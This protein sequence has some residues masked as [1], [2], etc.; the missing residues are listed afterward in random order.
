MTAAKILVNT[1]TARYYRYG[2]IVDVTDTRIN[3]QLAAASKFGACSIPL[4]SVE[5]MEDTTADEVGA[6][7][8]KVA[9]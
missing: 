8:A 1:P 4:C 3:L 2:Y 5:D 9:A 6:N 7:R